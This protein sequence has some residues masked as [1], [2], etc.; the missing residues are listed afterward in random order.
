M[1]PDLLDRQMIIASSAV[2]TALSVVGGLIAVLITIAGLVG[3]WAALRVGR[4]SQLISNYR[5]TA[6]SW[7]ARAKSITAEKSALEKQLEEAMVTITSLTTKVSTLQD[8]ATGHPAVEKLS[9][10]VGKSFQSLTNQLT[11]IEDSLRRSG[12]GGQNGGANANQ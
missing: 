8:L 12:N 11:R 9:R 4:N 5:A 7:E 3:T 6:E 1:L 2:T 10:E